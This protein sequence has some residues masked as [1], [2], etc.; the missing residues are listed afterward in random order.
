MNEITKYEAPKA[1]LDREI[2]LRDMID[3]A[4]QEL[5]S[6]QSDLEWREENYSKSVIRLKNAEYTLENLIRK[7]NQSGIMIE[8]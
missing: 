3:R 1:I 2:N 7:A 4:K 5:S 8:E 6:A